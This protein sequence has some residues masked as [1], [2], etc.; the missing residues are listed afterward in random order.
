MTEVFVF[1]S[2]LR[3]VH[4]AGSAKEAV[5]KYGAIPGQGEGRQ[6]NSYAI[7]T[8]DWNIYDSLP[9]TEIQKHVN[10]FLEYAREEEEKNPD[11]LF[12]IIDIGCGL[13]GY[14]PEEIAYFFADC[15]SNCIFLGEFRKILSRHWG[16]FPE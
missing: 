1:G 3:G 2:N 6:G 12:C 16:H 13:A 9:L 4:G 14:K 11:T 5:K 15:P 8:K 10:T 7:P